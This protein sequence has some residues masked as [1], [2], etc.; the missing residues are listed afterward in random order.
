MADD[1][2]GVERRHRPHDYDD[3]RQMLRDELDVEKRVAAVEQKLELVMTTA[4]VVKWVIFV[5]VSML[6]SL[7]LAYEWFQKHLK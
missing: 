5:V 6:G 3:L 4:G 1:W 7:G 2:D